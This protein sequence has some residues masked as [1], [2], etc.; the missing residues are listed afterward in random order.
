VTNCQRPN[1]PSNPRC[2]PWQDVTNNGRI[3]SNPQNPPSLCEDSLKS[4]EVERWGP[5]HCELARQKLSRVEP[6]RTCRVTA[7]QLSKLYAINRRARPP[8][9]FHSASDQD[10]RDHCH[11]LS[12]KSIFW[13]DSKSMSRAVAIDQPLNLRVGYKWRESVH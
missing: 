11:S 3:L 12:A 5:R 4:R 1:P 9:I 2:D 13:V 8:G 6:C 10:G 7:I